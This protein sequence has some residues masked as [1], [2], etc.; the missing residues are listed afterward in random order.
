VTRGLAG[1]AWQLE[2]AQL[3]SVHL[4]LRTA[5]TRRSAAR[6]GCKLA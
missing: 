4:L 5:R 6:A 3:G 1:H 2:E